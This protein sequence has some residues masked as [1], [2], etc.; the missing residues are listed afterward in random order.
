MVLVL[1]NDLYHYCVFV[2]RVRMKP[3][4]Q[5]KNLK[6]RPLKNPPEEER[7]EN[8]PEPSLDEGVEKNDGK[9][10]FGVLPNRD[11]KKNLGCG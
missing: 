2:Q 9:M 3:G 4:K 7:G 6:A 8:R 10:G 5:Q 1:S 11:L